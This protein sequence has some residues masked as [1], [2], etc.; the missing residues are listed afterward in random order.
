MSERY[1][2]RVAR[3]RFKFSCAHMTVFPDG[4]KER[5][6]GHNFTVA[7]ECELPS[8]DFESMLDFRAIKD[9]LGELCAEYK[10][11]LLLAENNPHLSITRRDAVELEFSLCGKR[12]VLPSEDVLLLPIDN[13]AVEPLARHVAHRLRERLAGALGAAKAISLEVRIEETPGQGARCRVSI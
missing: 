11:H 2:I 7:L 10:E 8:V 4:R 5:M 9:A 3:D 6:H 13:V 1:R 12:Y